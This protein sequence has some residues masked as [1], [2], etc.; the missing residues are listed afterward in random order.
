MIMSY[1]SVGL[2]TYTSFELL[3]DKHG[4][5][6]PDKYWHLHMQT[7]ELATNTYLDIFMNRLKLCS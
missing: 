5:M 7:G 4:N 2:F 1:S 3:L 6:L